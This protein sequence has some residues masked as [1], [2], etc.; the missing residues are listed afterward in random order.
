MIIYLATVDDAPDGKV[1]YTTLRE[2]KKERDKGTTVRKITTGR[3]TREVACA[4]FNREGFAVKQE[5]IE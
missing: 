4:L 2:A 1:A 5:E 3:I